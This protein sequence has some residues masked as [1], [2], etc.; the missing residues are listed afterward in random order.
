MLVKHGM[1]LNQWATI[2]FSDEFSR[3]AGSEGD[4]VLRVM[5]ASISQLLLSSGFFCMIEGVW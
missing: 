2:A 5:V 1:R 3:I 4:S